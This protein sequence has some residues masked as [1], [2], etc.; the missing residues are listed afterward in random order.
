M[1]KILNSFYLKALSNVYGIN[2]NNPV[3]VDNC[4]VLLVKFSKS[5]EAVICSL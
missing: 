4:S 3:V 2:C 1:K 5:F